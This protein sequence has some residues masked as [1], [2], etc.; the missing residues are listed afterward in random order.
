MQRSPMWQAG[1]SADAMLTPPGAGQRGNRRRLLVFA[2]VFAV[3]LLA[4]LTWNLSRPALYRATVKL[5][6]TQPGS[7]AARSDA[8]APPAAAADFLAQVQVIDSGP[9]LERLAQ[10]LGEMA[11]PLDTGGLDAV[12]ALRRMI[13]VRPVADTEVAEL[14][15][16]GTVAGVLAPVLNQLVLVYREQ[17]LTRYGQNNAQQLADLRHELE[18]LEKTAAER[19]NQIERFRNRAGIL[20]TERDENEAVARSRGL[21][22]ALN[23]AM[24][25]QAAAEARLAALQQAAAGGGGTTRAKDDP[26]LAALENRM[27]QAREEIRDMERTYTADFMAMDP[28]A[29]A[30]RA[31]LA[32]LERQVVQQRATS[33][34]S[35]LST[36]QE[37]AAAAAA[38]VASLRDQLQAER[39]GLRSFSAGFAQSKLLEDD[40]AQIEHA[41]RETLERLTKLDA[42]ERSREP[43]VTVL[44]PAV[45]PTQP[46]AP[47]YWRDGVLVLAASFVL[48]LLAM[49]FVELFNRAGGAAAA[50]S[51]TVVLPQ[52][53]AMLNGPGG[54][55]SLALPP[56]SPGLLAAPLPR[57][58]QQPEAAALLAASRGQARWV[59][60]A[61][62]LGL[63]AQE[64]VALRRR[65]LDA[66]AGTLQVGGSSA[67]SVR[68][69]AWL[70]DELAATAGDPDACLL[71]DGA[72]QPWRAEDLDATVNCAAVD[73]GIE[74]P[75][76]VTPQT[77]RNT[78]IGWLV[79]QG[80]RFADLSTLV[81]RIDAQTVSA[82]ARQAEPTQR[83]GAEDIDAVMPAL[84]LR[85]P[86]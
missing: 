70:V 69:P 21:G 20:S 9:Q 33:Q 73:A 56:A 68:L 61:G 75:E 10:R 22:V 49:G 66:A 64:L 4:G 45:T 11:V 55:P 38:T 84:R 6:I 1:A 86:A 37:E 17:L 80:L 36:A 47:D 15:A 51:T 16:T 27:S 54:P 57:E 77:L 24:E 39:Q 46:F 62:L 78:S 43:G 14:Q 32:E 59:C 85:P 42:A 5:Q 82:F 79:R 8:A 74:Q 34:G 7:V 3:C 76:G 13:V 67:R 30:L 52:P 83:R 18:R 48:A 44:E 23:S 26:T 31:R 53:W 60:A 63:T 50:P 29:R 65:D 2:V 58:L 72:G 71:Q 25:K 19:R 28:R 41:R 35:A 81:G 12:A 40:L